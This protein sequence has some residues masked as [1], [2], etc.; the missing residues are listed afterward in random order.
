MPRP[1]GRER[2]VRQSDC[3]AAGPDR[4]ETAR[5]VSAREHD[6]LGRQLRVQLTL[7]VLPEPRDCPGGGRRH[8]VAVLLPGPARRAGGETAAEGEHRH[9]VHL[10]RTPHQLRVRAGHV[11]SLQG[12]GPED[13]PR[14]Q[15]DCGAR[16]SA[17]GPAPD[18]RRE[19]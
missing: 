13:S 18:R 4:K 12:E 1:P 2:R 19:L 11:Q 15:R 14:Q 3:I 7:P 10:Q 17:A 6:P 8:R 5:T 9:R 16:S